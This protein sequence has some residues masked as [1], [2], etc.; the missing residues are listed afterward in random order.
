MTIPI[1][2]VSFAG[3]GRKALIHDLKLLPQ[4]ISP[5]L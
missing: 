4:P 3:Q 5:A 1:L 2:T